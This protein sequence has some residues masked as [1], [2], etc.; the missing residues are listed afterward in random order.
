MGEP[1]GPNAEQISYWNDVTGPKW[2]AVADLINAQLSAIGDQAIRL[3]APGPGERVL[4]I[5]CGSGFTAIELGRRVGDAGQIVGLDISKPMLKDAEARAHQAGQGEIQFICGDAQVHNFDGP[6]FDLLFS[7]FGVMFFEDP[8]A[9]FR[10][11][12]NALRPGGRFLF[13]CWRDRALNPWMT[14][15]ALVAS[16]FVTLPPPPPPDAPGPFAFADADHTIGLLSGAGFEDVLA[17]S[18]EPGVRIGA[19][20]AQAEVLEFILQMGPA[21]AALREAKAD[22]TLLDEV[23]VAVADTLAS[24]WD[25]DAYA[26]DAAVWLFSGHRGN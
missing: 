5:G 6:P 2:V 1:A 8:T 22:Q 15:P 14:V 20:R 10:N 26:M 23:R 12:A 21:G 7:R 24:Y 11:L 3:A 13:A 4:D 17:T 18:I 25:G 16:K 9:A 19:G